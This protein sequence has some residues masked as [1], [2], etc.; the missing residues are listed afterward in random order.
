MRLVMRFDT[1]A[2]R[3]RWLNTSL[4]VAKGRSLG[5]GSIE[6]AVYRLT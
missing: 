5:T 1:G 3:Y 6:Y 2:E 4:F